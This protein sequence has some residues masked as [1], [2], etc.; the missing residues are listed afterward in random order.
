MAKPGRDERRHN[1]GSGREGT[2]PHVDYEVAAVAALSMPR[3]DGAELRSL[4]QEGNSNPG[5]GQA[6]YGLAFLRYVCS[7]TRS[8]CPRLREEKKPSVMS[9][10]NLP[11]FRHSYHVI[12]RLNGKRRRH[13]AISREEVQQDC[14]TF[15]SCNDASQNTPLRIRQKFVP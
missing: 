11:N 4:P 7:F 5:R 15:I 8:C 13:Q 14:M 9:S 10:S 6:R 2:E 12:P 1:S 3:A